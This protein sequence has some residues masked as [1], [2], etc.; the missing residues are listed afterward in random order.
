MSRQVPYKC[1][2][3]YPNYT[4]I[5]PHHVPHPTAAMKTKPTT[6]PPND[7][8]IRVPTTNPLTILE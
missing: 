1:L 4:Y 6:K 8:T 2:L 3:L 5:H 7:H